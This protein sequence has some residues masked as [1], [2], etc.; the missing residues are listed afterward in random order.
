MTVSTRRDRIDAVRSRV[1]GQ[2]AAAPAG[3]IYLSPFDYDWSAGLILH[4]LVA[5]ERHFLAEIARNLQHAPPDFGPDEVL[6]RPLEALLAGAAY[7]RAGTVA[8]L[9][10][11]DDASLSQPLGFSSHPLLV[12]RT[13]LELLDFMAFHENRHADEIDSILA[14]LARQG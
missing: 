10:R 9:G 1:L 14:M 12:V 7:T 6:L 3:S 2:I 4:H 11:L 13:G 5:S 8:Y